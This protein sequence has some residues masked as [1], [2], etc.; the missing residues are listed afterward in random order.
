[1]ND[2]NINRQRVEKRIDAIT[3]WLT[4]SGAEVLAPTNEYELLR[5]KANGVLSIVYRKGKGDR[6]TFTGE[7]GK[8]LRS[9]FGGPKWEVNGK[10]ERR[11]TWVTP[12]IRTLIERDGSD[13]F[14]CCWPVTPEDASRDHL[15]PLASGGPSHIANYV[16]MHRDCNYQCGHMSAAEK[17]RMHDKALLAKAGLR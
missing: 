1:M 7:A 10:T 2:T 17:I 13:C 12:E 16:L 4:G 14:A 8:A 3:G 5:F 9:F 6:V 15:V 11:K